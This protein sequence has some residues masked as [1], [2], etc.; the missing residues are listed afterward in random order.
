MDLEVETTMM[1]VVIKW[2][3]WAQVLTREKMFSAKC[4]S[5]IPATGP[6]DAAMPRITDTYMEAFNTVLVAALIRNQVHLITISGLYDI[7]RRPLYS[8]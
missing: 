3:G 5:D 1:K 4:L 2:H 6:P 7:Y 8:C